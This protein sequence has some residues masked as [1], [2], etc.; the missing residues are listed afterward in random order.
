MSLVEPVPERRFMRSRSILVASRQ[1]NCPFWLRYTTKTW[2]SALDGTLHACAA[3]C[4]ARPAREGVGWKM[5]QQRT[6]TRQKYPNL[7]SRAAER[8][9]RTDNIE[10]VGFIKPE[11][12]LLQTE[13]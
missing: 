5:A 4:G 3:G 2:S 13:A 1:A 12:K 9:C 8:T 7:T 11:L 6:T 10:S